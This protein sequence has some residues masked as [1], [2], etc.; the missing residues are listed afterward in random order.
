MA[1]DEAPQPSKYDVKNPVYL[2]GSSALS[3]HDLLARF[4]DPQYLVNGVPRLT[5]LHLK[6]GE[7]ARYRFDA[8]LMPLPN[9][10]PLSPGVLCELLFPL[11]SQ[12]QIDTVLESTSADI[13]A[14]YESAELGLSF[15]INV[16]HDREGVAAAIRVLPSQVPPIDDLGLPHPDLANEIVSLKQG[17]VL[18]TGTTGSGKSTTLASLLQAINHQRRTRVITLEDPIEY[19]LASDKSLISQREVGNHVEGFHQGLRAALREDPDVIFV[20]EMRDPETTQMAMTAAE[21]GHLVLSTLHTR[22]A[23]GALTRIVDMYPAERTKEI[24]TQLSFSLN[25]VIGQKLIPRAD[26]R[27]RRA[28]FEVLRNTPAIGHVIRQGNWHQL[29]SI[30]QTKVQE[31]MV[32]LER[33]LLDL[34]AQKEITRDD[35]IRVANVPSLFD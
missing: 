16:F 24:T 14:G 33:H 20:G 35:A 21:T 11:L 30:M 26:G 28:V 12:R 2:V 6:V 7:P 19:V 5:D 31:G 25:L 29:Y 10:A 27:G 34:V 8:E 18:I 13:D 4:I 15:R 1:S 22:D 23:R 9:A 17:L 3:M 32:T